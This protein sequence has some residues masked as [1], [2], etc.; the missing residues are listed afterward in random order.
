MKQ[1]KKALTLV[2]LIV[3]T[4]ILLILWTMAFLYYQ[5]YTDNTRDSTRVFDTS[6]LQKSLELYKSSSWKFPEP[7][8][9]VDVTYSWAVAWTQWTLWI[10]TRIEFWKKTNVWNFIDPLTKNEYTYSVTNDRLEYQLWIA[11][12]VDDKKDSF[13]IWNRTYASKSSLRTHIVW[14]YNW[15]AV[16]VSTWGLDYYIT[17]PTIIASDLSNPKIL[18]MI[19]AKQISYEWYT[20][21]PHSYSGVLVDNNNSFDFS[22]WNNIVFSGTWSNL[23]SDKYERM[24]FYET[25]ANRYNHSDLEWKDRYVMFSSTYND[26]LNPTKNYI[27]YTCVVVW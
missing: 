9:W 27:N 18:E 4:T 23:F 25:M 15:K 22:G 2:E 20:N 21:L 6:K 24:K 19:E 3:V 12:E 13:L 1:D 16:K 8:N 5:S 26:S 10:K 7:T 14:N 11:L 17:T